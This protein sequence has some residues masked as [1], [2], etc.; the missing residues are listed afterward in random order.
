MCKPDLSAFSAETVALVM[1]Y[2]YMSN[3]FMSFAFRDR[4]VQEHII[5]T[6]LNDPDIDLAITSTQFRFNNIL[7]RE[8]TFDSVSEDTNGDVYNVEV[9]NRVERG[10][11]ERATYHISALDTQTV[12]KGLKDFRKLPKA[13]GIMFVSKDS[14]HNGKQKTVFEIRDVESPEDKVESSRLKYVII[15]VHKCDGEDALSQLCR[16]LQQSDYRKISNE[17][18][19]RRMQE[20]KEGPE[21]EEMCREEEEFG[22]RKYEKGRIEGLAEGDVNRAR[23]DTIKFLKM[24]WSVTKIA[25]FV[26]RSIEEVESWAIASGIQYRIN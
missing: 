14:L 25:E 4:D 23:M 26:E 10:G 3:R 5:R 6:G 17:H 12:H 22:K 15:N 18:L 13:N 21:A 9:E 16:D 7:G 19:A 1:G 8:I 20:I 2:S 11:L 24:N